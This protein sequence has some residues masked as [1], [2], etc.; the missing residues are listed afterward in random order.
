MKMIS[1]EIKRINNATRFS[2]Q[3]VRAAWEGEAAFR[4]EVLLAS[5]ML[6]VAIA[7]DV[8][9]L[10]RIALVATVM[11]VLIVELINSAIEA[12]VDRVGAELHPLS[13]RAKDLGS[14]AVFVALLL[15]VFTW[16]TILL[17]FFYRQ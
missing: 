11:L 15:A 2:M 10:E 1:K 9:S 14:A 7:L 12:T 16:A 13:G 5:I 8:N 3:G 4:V 17:E 6:P